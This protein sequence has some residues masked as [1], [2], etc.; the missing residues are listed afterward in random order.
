LADSPVQGTV[1]YLQPAVDPQ[2]R[3]MT[4]RIHVTNPQMRLRP[5]MFVQVSLETPLGT[6]VIAVP[7]SAVLDT[8]KEK[9]VYVAKANGVFEK[10][11]IE[12]SVAGDDYYAVTR[13]V[14]PGDRVVTHGSFLI[15]SQTRL[16]GTITGMFG[17]SKA[18]GGAGANTPAPA[19][20]SNYTVTLQS[21]PAPPKGGSEG[22]FHV[23]VTSPDGKPVTDAQVRVTMVMPAM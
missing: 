1:S 23:K 6:D 9:V 8:G 10:R 11:S 4:A 19:N 16:S 18:F 14:G 21:E 7:R 22:T 5:G 3:T 12:A 13:G 2:N 20:G 15:D 17:G